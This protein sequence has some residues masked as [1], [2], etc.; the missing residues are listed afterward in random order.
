MT[1]LIDNGVNPD[2]AN[3]DQRT[4]LH[5][6]ATKGYLSVVEYLLNCNANANAIDGWAQTPLQCAVLGGHD[7]VAS[8]IRVNGGRLF[9]ENAAQVNFQRIELWFSGICIMK[10]N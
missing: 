6:A 5:V 9:M 2:V 3:Y 8:L 7:L 10:G 4:A 1:R